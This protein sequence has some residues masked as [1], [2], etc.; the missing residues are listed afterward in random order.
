M[1][2]WTPKG[3]KN[4]ALK[5]WEGVLQRTENKCEKRVPRGLEISA[6]KVSDWCT[7]SFQAVYKKCTR[8]CDKTYNHTSAR[9]NNDFLKP[10]D[11]L[12]RF[13]GSSL[14]LSLFLS[15]SL[16]FS[17]F[18]PLSP[19]HSLSTLP[20]KGFRDSHQGISLKT[21]AFVGFKRLWRF[22]WNPLSIL[23]LRRTGSDSQIRG[24]SSPV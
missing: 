11:L 15:L 2:N 18:L 22:L 4:D 23:A 3:L 12:P 21:I 20:L 16:S 1:G 9:T 5:D 17:L 6:K 13:L 7:T 24:R 10:H 14:S 19:S 8:K